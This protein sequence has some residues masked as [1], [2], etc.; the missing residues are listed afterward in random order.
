MLTSQSGAIP[1][2]AAMGWRS[3]TS[4]GFSGSKSHSQPGRPTI[5][6]PSI[7]RL[8]VWKQ[9]LRAVSNAS[10]I[11]KAARGRSAMSH[12]APEIVAVAIDHP[13]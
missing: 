10:K 13:P 9:V 1:F 4:V 12:G 6:A 3:V 5:A 2:S 11:A 8:G 7:A